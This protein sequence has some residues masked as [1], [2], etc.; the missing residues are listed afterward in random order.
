MSLFSTIR[1]Y[2]KEQRFKSQFLLLRMHLNIADS[3]TLFVY[4]L[5]Q[6]VWL[7]TYQW[8]GG[9]LLCRI[10]KFFYTFSFYLNSFINSGI[11]LD[12]ACNTYNVN[13]RKAIE[14]VMRRVKKMVAVS[15]ISASLFSA[16]QLFIFRLYVYLM[17]G[18]ENLNSMYGK[19]FNLI[20]Q[21]YRQC[22][23]IWTIYKYELFQEASRSDQNQYRNKRLIEVKLNKIKQWEIVA[24]CIHLLLVFWVPSLIIT[25]SYVAVIYR[26]KKFARKKGFIK[27]KKIS[28]DDDMPEVNTVMTA[29]QSQQTS[30]PG[31]AFDIPYMEL[32]KLPA[33]ETMTKETNKSNQILTS[34]STQVTIQRATKL[35]MFQIAKYQAAVILIAYLTLWTPY[36]LMAFISIIAP[37]NSSFNELLYKTLP[38]LNALIVLNT[39]INPIIYG[40]FE[41]QTSIEK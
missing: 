3:I 37:L 18:E 24:S 23:P 14:K 16:P 25:L 40:F 36:N 12:R 39:V 2:F 5:T 15:Y 21:C 41:K 8:H 31:S 32:L 6:I 9:D 13:S 34:V 26:L 27:G 10:C 17:P 4:T 38:F 11:A 28:R 35:T 20:K 33:D 30:K 19:C 1:S 22:T 7:I 29:S